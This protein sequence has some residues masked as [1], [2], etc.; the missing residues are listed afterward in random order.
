[1]VI[2][3]QVLPSAKWEHEL[4]GIAFGNVGTRMNTDYTDLHELVLPHF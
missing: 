1:M 2:F 4:I 3:E